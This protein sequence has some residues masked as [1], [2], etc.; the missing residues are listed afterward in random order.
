MKL[1][2]LDVY[3]F[4]MLKSNSIHNYN[5]KGQGDGIVSIAAVFPS[6]P[7]ISYLRLEKLTN[8]VGGIIE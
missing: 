7:H 2:I 5:K 6:F 3:I 4:L 1:Y 8:F